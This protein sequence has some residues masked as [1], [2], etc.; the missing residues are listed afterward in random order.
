MSA[1]GTG[2]ATE[3]PQIVYLVTSSLSSRLMTGQHTFLADAGY[4]VAVGVGLIADAVGQAGFDAGVEV[5]DLGFRRPV[6]PVADLRSLLR[7]IRFLLRLRPDHVNVSTPKAAMIGMLA[8]WLTRVPHRVYV[9]RGL[10][11]ETMVGNGRR[12]FQTVERLVM[13]LADDVVFNS[14]SLLDVAVADGLIAEPRGRVLAGGSGNGIDVTRFDDAFGGGR[15]IDDPMSPVL[16]FVGRLTADKGLG[17][18]VE[19]FE[20]IAQER[21]G[22]RLLVVGGFEEDDPVDNESWRFIEHDPRVEHV[23]WSD[24]VATAYRSMD[25]LVFLSKR[26]GLP[27]VPMEAQASGV[28]VVG[29]A[30]TGTVDA[31]LEGR[32]GALAPIGDLDSIIER[33]NDLLDTPGRYEETSRASRAFVVERF[34]R[35]RVWDSLLEVYESAAK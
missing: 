26:E 32:N 24:D 34:A 9:V 35:E 20:R 18:L 14:Q 10:R 27:N 5:V 33:L 28:P 8:A 11:Y 30:A 13:K 7:T 1:R 4:R 29:F 22:A 19:L 23:G 2:R 25:V 6:A 15:R 3:N 16:G 21:P 17:E 12:F 31:V